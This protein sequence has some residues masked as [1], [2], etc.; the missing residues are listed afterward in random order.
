M[1]AHPQLAHA[2]RMQAALAAIDQALNAHMAGDTP[3]A[4]ALYRRHVAAFETAYRQAVTLAR[5]TGGD[6]VLA[7]IGRE[8]ADFWRQ[9]QAFLARRHS[10]VARLWQL[11][12]TTL[13]PAILV[14][15]RRCEDLAAE[16]LLREVAPWA[17][18]AF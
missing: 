15:Q 13:A 18:P 7:V 14:L 4:L 12:A 9:S 10:K 17:N 3:Q 8:F 11:Y 1:H 2:R 5:D 6:P 16:S